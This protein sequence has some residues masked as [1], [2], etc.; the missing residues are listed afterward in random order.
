M[1]RPAAQSAAIA[2][3]K[4]SWKQEALE[5][6]LAAWTTF[7]NVTMTCDPLRVR[8]K[9]LRKID[10]IRARTLWDMPRVVCLLR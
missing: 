5:L 8:T 7:V 2:Q 9:L 3:I 1:R 6:I 10:P 4:A